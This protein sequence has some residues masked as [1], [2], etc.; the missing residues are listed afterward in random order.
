MQ[1]SEQLVERYRRYMQTTHGKFVD[2]AE[3]Q[4]HLRNLADLYLCYA[5]DS[6]QGS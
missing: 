3:S 5:D 6:G 2:V 4:E 1:F